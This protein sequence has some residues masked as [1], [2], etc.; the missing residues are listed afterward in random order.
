MSSV[1]KK[2]KVK[3]NIVFH[4]LLTEIRQRTL[5]FLELNIFHNKFIAHNII[6]IQSGDSNMCG[7]YCI[8]FIEQKIA[9]KTLMDYTDLFLR[10]DYKNSDNIIYKN[11]KN[12]Y[13]KIKC[14]P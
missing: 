5:I 2:N 3:E 8:A 10:N 7:F 9:A 4:Y 11:F 13:G 6:R 12:K 14:K 1:S